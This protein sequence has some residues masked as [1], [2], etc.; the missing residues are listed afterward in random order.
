MCL[1]GDERRPRRLAEAALQFPEFA[2][3]GV[4][5]APAWTD[6]CR[7]E[8]ASWRF[9][10]AS[11]CTGTGVRLAC[12]SCSRMMPLFS[13]LPPS[14]EGSASTTR[15][16][17]ILTQ[18]VPEVDATS[19]CLRT[20]ELF[21][22]AGGLTLGLS[23]AGFEPISVVD[24]DG[25]A[26]ETLKANSED[27]HEH[28]ANWPVRR[29][30]VR[31]LAYD[32]MGT[33]DLLSAGAP[34]QPF[35]RGGR[36]LGE[37]DDRNMFGEVVRAVREL[38]PRAFVLENVRGLLFERYAEYFDYL[39]AQLQSPS[40][41]IQ[42]RWTRKS[43]LARLRRVSAEAHEYRVEWRL[44]NAADFGAPQYR[45]RLVIVGVRHDQ[46]EFKWP[47]ASYHR[48]ALLYELTQDEYWDEHGV[49]T[50]VR[51]RVRRALPKGDF[52]SS[53][54]RWRTARDVTKSLGRPSL[55]KGGEDYS[56]VF[57]PGARLYP[58]HTGSMLDWPAK[59]VKAGVHGCPGGEHILVRDDGTYRYFTV[60]ECAVLQGF[61][62][63]YL[64]PRSRTWAMRLLGNAVPVPLAEAVGRSLAG[65][66][67]N[68]N[69]EAADARRA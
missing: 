56:H 65:V 14:S 39:I 61:P 38:Q 32:D 58:K 50:S 28:T 1:L 46:A 63:D 40:L 57:V 18:P 31:T 23:N 66:L 13:G 7:K 9:C 47:E 6:A 35:S 12:G 60:R 21:S 53:G 54:S 26:I 62:T 25:V 64:L 37:N 68:G 15:S 69:K 3:T 67:S 34:C 29:A 22:G 44:L 24:W 2:A 52:P 55:G 42:P 17:G 8:T 5:R 16:R 10:S 59:T 11:Q 4:G 51:T 33:T 41:A 20:V 45:V 48:E 36:G 19:S 49:S 30:D 27:G 43:H